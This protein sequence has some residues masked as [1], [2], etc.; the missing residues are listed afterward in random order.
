MQFSANIHN[1][2]MLGNIFVRSICAFC[3]QYGHEGIVVHI[4]ATG[5]NIF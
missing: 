2:I 5:S 1:S 4:F 3:G